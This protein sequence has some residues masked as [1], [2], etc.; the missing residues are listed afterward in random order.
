MAAERPPLATDDALGGETA[1][2]AAAYSTYLAYFGSY[3]LEGESVV[4]YIDG[5][6]F[7]NWSGEKQVR[8]F[9]AEGDEL[10]LR[11]PPMA[12]DSVNELVWTRDES[13]PAR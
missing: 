3:E 5:S 7:P 4:H 13:S 11:T 6:L 9:V 12:D 8:P 1:A 10:I 2:R